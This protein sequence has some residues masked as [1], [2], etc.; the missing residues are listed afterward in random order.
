MDSIVPRPTL[1]QVSDAAFDRTAAMGRVDGCGRC[2]YN[3]ESPKDVADDG[4]GG[5]YAGYL[6]ADCG[7]AWMT[8]WGAA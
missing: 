4:T 3:H 6:C 5:F 8:S 7:H 2:V 1:T